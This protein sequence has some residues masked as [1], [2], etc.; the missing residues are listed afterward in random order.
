[1]PETKVIGSVSQLSADSEFEHAF[2]AHREGRF[3]EAIAAYRKALLGA[4]PRWEGWHN[5]AVL[6]GSQGQYDEAIQAFEEARAMQPRRFEPL[7]DMAKLHQQQGEIAAACRCF[8]ELV[9]IGPSA[10]HYNLLGSARA[11]GGERELAI[12]AFA[13]AIRLQPRHPVAH[14]NLL[15]ALSHDPAISPQTLLA[16]HR[17]WDRLNTPVRHQSVTPSGRTRGRVRIG[18]VSPDFRQHALLGL[19][20]PVFAQHDRD[21]FEIHAYAN[22]QREDEA[23]L[24]LKQQVDRW[25]PIAG[26]GDA[27]V[28]DQIRRDGIDILIDLAGHTAGNRL[29]VFSLKPAPIQMA[30]LGYPGTTGLSTMDYRL[31]DAQA[32]PAESATPGSETPLRL[33][34]TFFCYEPTRDSA[35]PTPNRPRAEGIVFGA[36]HKLIKLNSEVLSLWADILLHTP[37]SRLRIVRDS[38][39]DAARQRLRKNFEQAGIDIARLELVTI[40]RSSAQRLEHFLGMDILL[41]TFPWNG[42]ITSLEALWMNVPVIT[43]KGNRFSGRMSASLLHALGLDELIAHTPGDYQTIARALAQSPERLA[44]IRGGLRQRLL[45]S[46]VCNAA[47]FTRDLEQVYRTLV[48]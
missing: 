34:S 28:A 12:M 21:A 25:H 43:L 17:W 48:H 24:R 16:E 10:A 27:Q 14:S 3:D 46:A 11:M 22:L 19:I 37:G 2:R 39:D 20:E 30:W 38:I 18:Y 29:G 15:L 33:P 35:P 42:H 5:L 8:E 13:E 41:D 4:N 47:S 40:D 45:E 36:P 31:I 44:A 26:L 9:R 1:M 23:S 32:D 7:I 6:L